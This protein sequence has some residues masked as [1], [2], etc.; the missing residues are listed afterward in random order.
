[1]MTKICIIHN[2]LTRQNLNGRHH[3]R[4]MI[5]VNVNIYELES[6]KRS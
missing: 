1:M 2:L 4:S 5:W 6:Y 3:Y